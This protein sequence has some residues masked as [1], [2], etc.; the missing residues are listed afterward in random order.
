MVPDIAVLDYGV[1]NLLSV[2]RA[3]E[4]L[5]AE[6]KISSD[7]DVILAA[8]HVVL[9]GVG[10]FPN[11]M[12]KLQINNL[13]LV[14][15]EVAANGTAVLAICLGMQLLMQESDEF[16]LTAGLGLL[17]GRV[18]AI[19]NFSV[20]GED[21]KVPHIGW[22]ALR[23]QSENKNWN[24]TILKEVKSGDFVYFVHS[25]MVKPTNSS[26]LLAEAVHGG[27]K[28]AAVIS[29]DNIVGC[30]FHPEKSGENG[31]RILRRFIS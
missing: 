29:K 10:A 2:K 13:D 4:Y 26:H 21:L 27:H 22:N 14:V 11:A 17:P 28:I 31:L 18:E 25:F 30:Q 7:P 23:L 20:S 19:P 5:G 16:G 9:P 12:K 1:G 15:K 8:T 3:F 6:V 24:E